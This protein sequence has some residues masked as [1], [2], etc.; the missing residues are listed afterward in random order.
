MHCRRAI[1]VIIAVAAAVLTP[2]DARAQ[3]LSEPDAPNATSTEQQVNEILL[4]PVTTSQAI[5]NVSVTIVSSAYLTLH[6]ES[7]GLHLRAHV[8]AD[9]SDLQAKLGTVIDSIPLPQDNCRSYSADNPVVTLSGKEL[10]AGDETATLKL[11]G[12]VDIWDCRENPI[13]KTKVKMCRTHVG[14]ATFDVPCGVEEIGK[15]DP[16]KNHLGR[17]PFDVSVPVA[18]VKLD[19]VSV[20]LTFGDPNVH[21]SGQ[22]VILTNGILHLAGLDINA[23]ARDLL[24][25][26]IDPTKLRAAIP[27]EFAD[28]NPSIVTASFG[29]NGGHL[30]AQIILLAKVPETTLTDVLGQMIA[31]LTVTPRDGAD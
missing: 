30:T 2:R 10:Q 18:L 27:K 3:A 26:V 25:E 29:S 14:L 1:L 28:L 6:A 12:Y 21:L 4:G 22:Y 16:I 31:K 17:Q 5:Q 7:D 8:I 19:D 11:Q 20:A 9:L 15:G 24:Q 13:P 23:K